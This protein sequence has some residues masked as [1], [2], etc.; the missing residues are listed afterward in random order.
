M[1]KNIRVKANTTFPGDGRRLRIDAH[2]FGL[3]QVAPQLE[4]SDRQQIAENHPALQAVFEAKP[5]LVVFCRPARR[6]SHRV[7]LLTNVAPPRVA[8]PSRFTAPLVSYSMAR[9]SKKFLSFFRSM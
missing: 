6:A 2:L 3:A 1:I 4:R 9:V 5:Q 7:E 8:F